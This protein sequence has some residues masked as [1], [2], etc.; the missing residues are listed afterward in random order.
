MFVK[1]C[2]LHDPPF[3]MA[4]NNGRFFEDLSQYELECLPTVREREKL[5]N[6][7]TA[8]K[9]DIS[10]NGV[11][12][13]YLNRDQEC[14][15]N[16]LLMIPESIIFVDSCAFLI[17]IVNKDPDSPKI[18]RFSSKEVISNITYPLP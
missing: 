15:N 2:E 8:K 4:E 13:V 16:T 12:T 17:Q 10:P 6:L 5:L 18:F 11:E 3:E 7:H 9:Q 1:N 14:K